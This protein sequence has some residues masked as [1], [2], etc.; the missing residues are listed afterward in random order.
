M[1]VIPTVSAGVISVEI[2]RMKEEMSILPKELKQSRRR[3]DN[4]LYLEEAREMR[5]MTINPISSILFSV[6]SVSS[7]AK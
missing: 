1:A 2:R 4:T 5:Y 7:W 6:Q 3:P